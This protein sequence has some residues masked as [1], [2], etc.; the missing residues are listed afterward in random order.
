MMDKLVYFNSIIILIGFLTIILSKFTVKTEHFHF[1]LRGINET[2]E[3]K[4]P[5]D[6]M[7]GAGSSAFQTEG[8]WNISQKGES[9]WDRMTHEKP[10]KVVDGSNADITTNFYNMYKTDINLI[11]QINGNAYRISISWSRV[12]PTG[13][14][15]NIN[16]DGILYYNNVINEMLRQNI[17]PFVT[18]Y[19]WDL[20]QK[21]QDLGGWTNPLIIDWFVDY[22]QVLFTAFGDRVKY[23]ITINEPS[24]MCYFGYNGDFAPGI[25][26]SGVGDYLCGH[27]ALIA[28]ARTYRMYHEEFRS[29]QN[30]QVG[31]GLLLTWQSPENPNDHKEVS[32][33][34]LS[35]EFWNS[36]FLHPIFSKHGDYPHSM[37]HRISQLSHHQGFPRSRLPKLTKN[38]IQIIQNSVDYLGINFHYSVVVKKLPKHRSQTIVSFTGDT[39]MTSI[40]STAIKTRC[41]PSEMSKAINHMLNLYK[42][43]PSIIITENGYEDDGEVVDKNRAHFYHHNLYQVLKLISQG[44]NIRGY[45]AWSLTDSFEWLQGY[46]KRYGIFSVNFTDPQLPRTPKLSSKVLSEIYKNKTVINSFTLVN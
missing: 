7:L 8:A 30:G 26:Q 20:P 22:A 36:W 18:I 28:H 27:H 19:H 12:M 13:F 5:D 42:N 39:G 43:I 23:W 2:I 15:N 11:K 41:T 29:Q 17:T 24:V 32:G 16:I 40:F 3:T 21:L 1:S 4:F 37:K 38:Q 44:V 14:S 35:W 31:I 45:F 34:E 6:F 25:N 9:I 10:H 46:S 33:A